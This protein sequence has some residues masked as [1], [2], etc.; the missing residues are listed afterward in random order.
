M[1][2]KKDNIRW[3]VDPAFLDKQRAALRRSHRQVIYLNGQELAAIDAY[4]RRF[5][6]RARAS[7]LRE[8]IMS[9]VLSELDENHPTLF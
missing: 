2:R 8:A 4:C 6:V 7:F 3:G 5:G 1:A 9:K